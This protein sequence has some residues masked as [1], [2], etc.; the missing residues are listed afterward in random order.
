MEVAMSKP[1]RADYVKSIKPA[2]Y[3]R[4]S[5]GT[6]IHTYDVVYQP[7]ADPAIAERVAI[8]M[9]VDRVLSS[10]GS[11]RRGKFG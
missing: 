1:A 10:N 4:R 11:A 5:D 7:A 9:A 6:S 8:G 3:E 2:G